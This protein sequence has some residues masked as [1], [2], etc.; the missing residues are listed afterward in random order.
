LAF[1]PWATGTASNP[2][3]LTV[4]NTG[5]AALAGGTFT[6]GGGTPQ[7]FSRP[8]GGAG[9]SCGAG[10]AVGASCTI[11]VRFA[12]T[13][14]GAI[15]RTLTVAYT[16]ATVTGS[17]VSLTGTGVTTR[18]TLTVTPVTVTLAAGTLSGT[19]TVTVTNNAASASSVAITGDTVAGAGL[20]WAWTKDPGDA[21]LGSNLAPGASCTVTVRFTRVGSAGTHVG[22]ISFTDTATG[23]P[24]LAVLTGIAH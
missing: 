22:S 1:G 11:N 15:S 7:P 8:A 14:T 24:Q 20:I 13:A 3:T 4:T 21:C 23:S 10:L 19:G 16:G 9:G 2:L 12:P 5:N 6:F 18:G 17:P